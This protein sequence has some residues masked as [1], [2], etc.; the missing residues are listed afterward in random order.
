M[1]SES[2]Y[3]VGKLSMNL[4]PIREMSF[5]LVSLEILYLILSIHNI[6]LKQKE[7][8]KKKKSH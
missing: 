7:T 6:K 1:L 4:H 5:L 2:L 3:N 8:K